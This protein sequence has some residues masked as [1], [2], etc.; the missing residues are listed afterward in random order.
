MS[1][2]LDDLTFVDVFDEEKDTPAIILD[3]DGAIAITDI[4]GVRFVGDDSTF[5]GVTFHETK[6]NVGH[7]VTNDNP[8][9]EN[10]KFQILFNNRKS[11]DVMISALERAATTMD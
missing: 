7:E 4:H 10:I 5:C 9:C 11:I 1:K 2:Y 6:V 3:G 8:N